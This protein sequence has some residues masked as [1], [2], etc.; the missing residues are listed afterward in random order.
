[1]RPVA[2]AAMAIT[3]FSALVAS[4]FGQPAEPLQPL[5]RPTVDWQAGALVLD[6]RFS[7]DTAGLQQD[8]RFQ[9]ERELQRVLPALFLQAAVGI[10]YDSS[11]TVGERIHESQELYF[12]LS[13]RGSPAFA[14]KE[15]S[16]LAPDLRQVEVGY[17]FPLYGPQG[18][19]V[20]FILHTHPY[21]MPRLLGFVPTRIFSGL[22]IDARG[23]LPAHGKDSRESLQPALFPKLYDEQMNLVLSPEMC[24]PEYLGRWGMAAYAYEEDETPFFERIRTTPLRTAARGVFGI[25]ATDVILPDDAVRRLL[26]LEANQAMLRQC[27]ILIIVD[28]PRTATAED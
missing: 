24:E 8:Y 13:E 27:R 26:T 16:R 23:Q 10:L 1:M 5:V 4:S 22:V 15:Y 17:R 3:L 2:V 6:I 20:P 7:L 12:S 18:L 25:N 19:A 21:P 11:R 9:A 28:P 14:R